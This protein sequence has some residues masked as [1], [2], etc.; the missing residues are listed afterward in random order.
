MERQ[1]KIR[2]CGKPMLQFLLRVELDRQFSEDDGVITN[3][4][5]ICPM[6]DLSARP[7]K[8]VRV[9]GENIRDDAGIHQDHAV[10]RVSRSQP[11]VSPLTFPPRSKVAK[12]RFPRASLPALTTN[13]P[14]GWS[15]NS[16]SCRGSNP[17]RFRNSGGMV[18]CPLFVTFMPQTLRVAAANRKQRNDCQGNGD[19]AV[20]VIPLTIPLPVTRCGPLWVRLGGFALKAGGS[21]PVSKSN[22]A[23]LATGLS[24]TE[25]SSLS[26]CLLFLSFPISGFSFQLSA[27]GWQLRRAVFAEETNG[28]GPKRQQE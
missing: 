16:T 24:G 23:G 26:D 6:L 22:Q 1:G 20:S 10:P 25:A 15:T 17:C 4:P 19:S 18:T 14:S 3:R 27:F 8:S 9:L 11:A 21:V 7:C 28:T 12:T 13:T 2:E 5:A